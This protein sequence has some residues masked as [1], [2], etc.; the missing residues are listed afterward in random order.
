[1]LYSGNECATYAKSQELFFNPNCKFGTPYPSNH[2]CMQYSALV[3][4]LLS[5]CVSG[6]IHGASVPWTVQDD[7]QFTKGMALYGI[8]TIYSF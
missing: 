3:C 6:I 2:V 4:A 5:V 8:G 7:Q 1:M